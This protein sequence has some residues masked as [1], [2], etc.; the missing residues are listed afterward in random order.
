M[1]K[2]GTDQ[3]YKIRMEMCQA[4]LKLEKEMEKDLE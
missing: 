4:C 1:V 2:V 3:Q